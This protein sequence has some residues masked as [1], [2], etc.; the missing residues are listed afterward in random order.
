MRGA[1]ARSSSAPVPAPVP[2]PV[3]VPGPPPAAR[4]GVSGAA[5]VLAG[6][7]AWDVPPAAPTLAG[8]GGAVE[9]LG[10]RARAGAAVGI[11]GGGVAG[12]L[13]W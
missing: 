13:S 10:I 2:V 6:G 8:T 3:P 11:S 9:V 5:E 12:E 4:P 1:S 7:E